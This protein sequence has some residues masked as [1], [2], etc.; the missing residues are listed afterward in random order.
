MCGRFTLRNY[1]KAEEQFKC[2]IGIPRRN[3]APG[4]EILTITDLPR[5]MKWGFTPYWADK[6]FNF[7]NARSETIDTKPSFKNASRCLIPSD[8]WYEWKQEDEHK[9]PYFHHLEEE[10]FCFAGVFGGFRGKMGC[11]ILTMKA[12]I[13]VEHIHDRA[14]VIIE[15][16]RRK[17]WLEGNLKDIYASNVY[18]RVQYYPVSNHVNN[19]Q[20]DDDK[21]LKKLD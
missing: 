15:K 10:I 20:V 16:S 5:N 6:P 11:A 8:G 21:C 13:K 7:I 18:E 3:I 1:L 2:D 9:I 4:Q 17:D 14:P 12:P 19:P